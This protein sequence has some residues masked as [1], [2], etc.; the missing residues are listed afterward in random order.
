MDTNRN[1]AGPR[2]TPVSSAAISQ[3]PT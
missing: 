3:S 2:D 1:P